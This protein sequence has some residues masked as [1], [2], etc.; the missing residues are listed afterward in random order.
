MFTELLYDY[1]IDTKHM[2]DEGTAVIYNS[3]HNMIEKKRYYPGEQ[4]QALIIDCGGGTTD[5]ASSRFI[6]DN[7]NVSYKVNIET[8]YE[9]GDTNFGGNN[10][11]Y[12]IMQY[13][14]IMFAAHYAH[15]NYCE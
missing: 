13:I 2:L 11:T 10:I 3:I 14:K 6:I 15:R 12:R 5:L 9:N 8:T 4:T 1:D 7:D